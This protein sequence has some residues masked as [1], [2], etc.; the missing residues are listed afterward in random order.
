MFL[1]LLHLTC[2]NKLRNQGFM[3]A[4]HFHIFIMEGKNQIT[5]KLH[6]SYKS[7]PSFYNHT[8]QTMTAGIT[9]TPLAKLDWNPALEKCRIQCG[10]LGYLQYKAR[11]ENKIS[12]HHFSSFHSLD[13]STSSSSSVG[14]HNLKKKK[15]STA[16]NEE[17]HVDLNKLTVEELNGLSYYK[18]LGG[19]KMHS[20]QEQIKR[21]FHKACLKY[22]PDKEEIS[23]GEKSSGDDPVF[24]KVKEAFETLSDPVKRKSYDS[25]LEFDDSIPDVKDVKSDA[26]FYRVF[27]QC[28]ERNLRFA[29]QNDP[30][31][32]TSSS[33]SS[34]SISSKK[35]KGKQNNNN[36]SKLASDGPP[37]LGDDSTPIEHVNAF[38]EYWVH[39]DSWRDFTLPATQETEMD[40]DTA[41]DRYEKRWMEKEIQRRAKAMKKDE[42]ARIS[43]LVERSMALDPRLRREKERLEQ[44]KAEKLRLKQEQAERE[45]KER[46]EAEEQ[47]AKERAILEQREKDQKAAEKL[48]KETEKKM[49]R[50]SRQ[51]LRKTLL[52]QYE[53]NGSTMWDNIEDFSHDMESLCSNLSVLELDKLT[54]EVSQSN[55]SNKL[56]IAYDRAMSLKNEAERAKAIE[57]RERDTAR[58]EARR[59]EEE[60]KAARASK[61]WSKEELAALAKAVKKHPAGGSRWDTI[62]AYVNSNCRLKDPRTKEEC[63]EMYNQVRSGALETEIERKPDG[64]VEIS[65]AW[66]E[67]QDKLLQSALAK[68]PSTM[69]KNERWTAIAKMIPGK[70]KKDCVAR[71]K[72][73]REALRKK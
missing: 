20:T 28:F 21:A 3:L 42:M 72:E 8:T 56:S 59:K 66:T 15:E 61:P 44:E 50:K 14:V 46:A 27:G 43:R 32:T 58:E 22:H 17:S 54:S 65:E 12:F 7:I 63:I 41:S 16:T 37:L 33:S 45:A 13:E 47:E 60:A 10:T 70:K 26:D 34:T 36:Q 23:A 53:I 62:A 11:K 39:F 31:K 38:Y 55:D 30:A 5:S 4:I 51:A 73:I 9:I 2:T 35:K 40:T 6:D 52:A 67:D 19:I 71:F 49:L 29:A 48:A 68:Y 57:K 64:E 18:V 24:L 69:D 1:S 25:T